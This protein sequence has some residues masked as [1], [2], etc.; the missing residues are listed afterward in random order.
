M[1][2]HPHFLWKDLFQK[3]KSNQTIIDALKE[4]VLFCTLN[5]RELKTLSHIVYERVYQPGEDVFHQGDRGF[6]M[7]MI[8]KG[9]IVIK[10]EALSGE[11]MIT[12][13]HEGSFFGELSL[14]DPNNIRTA[15]ATAEGKTS[16]VGFFKPDLLEI[17]E[18]KPQMGVKILFQ[19]SS[20]LGRRL[21]ET[22]EKITLMRKTGFVEPK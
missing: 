21:L 11:G 14:V 22:T 20:V 5:Q 17:L 4:N 9:S 10:T 8:L 1:I 18:R 16:L 7:Y 6:G 15:T 19:L 13:L 3:K 12:K 2:K